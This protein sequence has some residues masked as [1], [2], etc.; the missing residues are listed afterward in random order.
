MKKCNKKNGI[1]LFA[2]VLSIA[3]LLLISGGFFTVLASNTSLIKSGGDSLQAQYFAQLE[4]DTLKLLSYEEID[5]V[6]QDVWE[7]FEID[8]NWQHKINVGPEQIIGDGENAIKIVTVDVKK[9][10]D[11]IKRY[12]VEVPFSSQ[13]NRGELVGTIIPRMS[14]KFASEY[15]AKQYLL[16]DGSTFDTTK[17]KKLY[18]VLGTNRLPNLQGVFLRGYGTQGTYSSGQLGQIQGDAM[19]KIHGDIPNVMLGTSLF[20]QYDWNMISMAG[21]TSVSAPWQSHKINNRSYGTL[22]FNVPIHEYILEKAS[23]DTYTIRDIHE[24]TTVPI[25]FSDYPYTEW[26]G[27]RNSSLFN[28]GFTYRTINIDSS[29]IVPT[30]KETRPANVAVKYYIRAK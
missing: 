10:T 12:S 26:G 17:Y 1:A 3:V 13:S 24:G 23:D 29:K 22:G 28:L 20:G 21:S 15:E 19:R 27:I 25:Y 14:D 9:S 5:D 6:E 18:Q 8:E 2:T 4:A 11:T 30:D 16:C 7:N